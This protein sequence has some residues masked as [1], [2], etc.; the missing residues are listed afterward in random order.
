MAKRR[1]KRAKSMAPRRRSS[2]RRS[3]MGSVNLQDV[4][5]TL[6]GAVAS[7]FVV[8]QLVKV[9]PGVIKTPTSKAIAQVALGA[10]TKPLAGLVGS[11]SPMI[12]AFGK[13][14]MIGGGYEL[15][16]VSVPAAFGQT[17]DQD[18]IVVN[19]MDISEIN[20]MDDIGQ[21]ISEINGLDEIGYYN[22]EDY[23]E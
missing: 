16:K 21:D 14:M 1:T 17:D 18:V 5:A 13:G 20:G 22:I 2:K 4:A 15:L 12:D 19:G 10:L 9:V 3:M 23:N 8:N 11:K 7:R 6:A